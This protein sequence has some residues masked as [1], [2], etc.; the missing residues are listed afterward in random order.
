MR[1]ADS[2]IRSRCSPMANGFPP[3][4]RVTSYTESPYRKPRSNTGTRASS[5]STT[6]PPIQALPGISAPE[7]HR[8]HPRQ[9]LDE[10]L[11]RH[12]R[13]PD[14]PIGEQDRE[15]HPPVA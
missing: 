12:L 1:R 10:Y 9:R 14:P 11:A 3:N 15:L 13:L 4:E 8:P 2:S 5:A 6:R 7:P